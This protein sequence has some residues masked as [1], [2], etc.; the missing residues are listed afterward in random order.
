[1]STKTQFNELLETLELEWKHPFKFT[2]NYNDNGNVAIE[3]YAYFNTTKPD[4]EISDDSTILYN[5][6]TNELLDITYWTQRGLD[7]E[8]LTSITNENLLKIDENY[9]ILGYELATIDDLT[10]SKFNFSNQTDRINS[11]QIE[12]N[13][14]P[15][16]YDSNKEWIIL[17]END[18]YFIKLNTN[19][20]KIY[21]LTKTLKESGNTTSFFLSLSGDL[22][23]SDPSPEWVTIQDHIVQITM[24][25]K[26]SGENIGLPTT[27]I[28]KVIQAYEP[29]FEMDILSLPL[30]IQTSL[31][32]FIFS[33]SNTTFAPNDTTPPLGLI[34]SGADFID[35]QMKE[36]QPTTPYQ[37]I[38][39][40]I[41]SV[42][43]KR[44]YPIEGKEADVRRLIYIGGIELAKAELDSNLSNEEKT[45]LYELYKK[46]YKYCCGTPSGEIFLFKEGTIGLDLNVNNIVLNSNLN[47]QLGWAYNNPNNSIY[48]ELG[49]K[50]ATQFK[51]LFIPNS[52]TYFTIPTSEAEFEL[53]CKGFFEIKITSPVK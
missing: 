48:L 17:A 46:N 52:W 1:M 10:F 18:N 35:V 21:L 42:V 29:N 28:G 20:K 14:Y 16:T 33:S 43:S 30:T 25:G 12:N 39:T 26:S 8:L 44:I 34:F 19:T 32:K 11:I 15:Y 51:P 38:N 4:Q 24:Q 45:F 22:L 23:M 2:L 36:L 5:A 13:Y 6:L 40:D 49:E 47:K 50:I 9:N 7:E 53:M 31:G 37:Y 27:L 3:H 41:Y